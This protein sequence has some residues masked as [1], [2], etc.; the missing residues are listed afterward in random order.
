MIVLWTEIKPCDCRSD[1]TMKNALRGLMTTAFLVLAVGELLAQTTTVIDG[2][3]SKR[4]PP[5]GGHE[6]GW[7]A[8]VNPDT[9]LTAYFSIDNSAPQPG[10]VVN[11]ELLITN[12]GEKAVMLPRAL[13][14]GDVES[15]S[16]EQ[17][18]VKASV[19]LRLETNNGKTVSVSF[20]P[21]T[22]DLY[23]TVAKPRTA[24]VL[25]PGDSLRVLGASVLP[26][27]AFSSQFGEG[28]TLL[29]HLCVSSVSLLLQPSVTGQRE[30]RNLHSQSLWC[31]NA[32]EKYEVNYAPH[33]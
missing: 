22:L 32:N 5:P 27:K 23:S 16:A 3:N 26:N 28:T 13:D 1:H 7:S 31:V 17:K 20:L 12:T 18:Y 25:R 4:V 24:L 8:S 6:F 2:R 21:D 15:G 11:Y 33:P 29:G 10:S 30:A 14:W 19:I 9:T